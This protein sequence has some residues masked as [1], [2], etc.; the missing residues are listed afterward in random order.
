VRD[1]LPARVD[2]LLADRERVVVGIAGCPGAGKSTL[3]S[4][5]V[6]HLDP[7]LRAVCVPMDGFHLADVELDRLGRRDRKGAIDTFDGHGYLA[8]LARLRT[9]T[10]NVV[11]APGF[12]RT[13]EQPIAGQ[14]PVF[15]ESRVVVTEGNYLLDGTDPWSGVRGLLDEVWFCDVDDA[16]R[17]ERLVRRHIQFGKTPEA[18]RA[19]VLDV[20]ERNAERIK[21]TADRADLSL[22]TREGE[23]A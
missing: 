18:A 11:Y 13:I 4:W 22:S 5:L 20:D 9:E 14:L 16:V 7:A 12:D 23:Q 6:S 10:G 2:R 21:A 1:D 19:W 17:R 8:L 15:P 3:A